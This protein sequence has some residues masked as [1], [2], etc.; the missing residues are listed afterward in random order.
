MITVLEVAGARPNYM[1]VAPIHRAM[2]N[3]G[4][5][6]PLFVHTGQHY[7]WEMSQV[8]MRDLGLPTPDV[9]LGVGSGSHAEQTAQVMLRLEPVLLE[10]RPDVVVVVG[11]VNSTLGAALAAVKVQVPVAHVE[12]GLRSFDRTMPEEINR[13]LTDA[14]S[15]LLFAPS[16]DA[17]ANLAAEGIAR[18]K[19]HLVGNVMIDSLESLFRRAQDSDVLDR[20]GVKPGEYL[21]ATLH[22]PS[23]VDGDASLRLVVDALSMAAASL[24]V[25]L[26]THPRTRKRLA[27]AGLSERVAS[28]GVQLLDP[29][30]YLDFLCLMSR[31][32]GVLTDSGGIQEETTVLGVPCLT[33]R[34]RTE[35]PITVTEGTN[36]VVGLDR[37]RIEEAVRRLANGQRLEPRRPALWDGCAAERIVDVLGPRFS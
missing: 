24:P 34:D 9:E 22:R 35:R 17:V 4:G 28:D 7:D 2:L 16:P 8:F 12:A 30:G 11:D 25:L 19:I 33:L 26:V 15:E 31:A 13:L 32:A 10:R 29:L 21:V 23:N 5:F 20:L 27:Q 1:K 18:E 3:A 14:M 37:E 6:A 36:Q